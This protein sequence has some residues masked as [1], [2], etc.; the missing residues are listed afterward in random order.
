MLVS[1]PIANSALFQ[2]AVVSLFFFLPSVF[3]FFLF[4]S[5]S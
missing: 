1:D 2:M 4:P 3:F 5:M